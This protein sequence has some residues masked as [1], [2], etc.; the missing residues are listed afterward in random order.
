[1]SQRSDKNPGR[2]PGPSRDGLRSGQARA[3]S[4]RTERVAGELRAIIGEVIARREIKD[5]RVQ[6]A[7]LITV[8]HVR[9]S[10]DLRQARALFTVHTAGD[11]EP[12]HKRP[13]SHHT[14][15]HFP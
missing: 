11:A 12:D 13:T 8:T 5:P 4:T 15:P 7:G 9:V 2:V 1:M 3:P 6:G 14:S 10:G